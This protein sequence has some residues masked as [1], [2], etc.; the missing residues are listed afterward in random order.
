[1]PIAI[2]VADLFGHL[3]VDPTVEEELVMGDYITITH[4]EKDEICATQKGG[5]K[6]L[7]LQQIYDALDISLRKSK[8]I[9]EIVKKAVEEGKS[10]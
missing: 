4:T 3:I 1:M 8:E 6:G 5:S 7:T 2:T 9:R 10:G